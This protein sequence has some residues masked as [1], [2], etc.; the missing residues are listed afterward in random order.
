MTDRPTAGPLLDFET[1]GAAVGSAVVCGALSVLFPFL[2]APT[3]T[4][5]ALALAGWVSLARR[6]GSLTWK[7]FG[8][9]P[10]VALGV[11]GGA[12]LCFLI[13]PPPLVPVRGL[14]V[15]ASLVPL[16]LTERTCSAFR[17]PVFSRT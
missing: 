17:S 1:F 12:A 8:T 13:P 2:I 14:L 15:A 3:A 11:L 7:G 10:A 9:R 5:A 16:F 4:L 6:R